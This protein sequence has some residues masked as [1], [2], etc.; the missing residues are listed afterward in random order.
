MEQVGI[1]AAFV[2]GVLSFASPCVLPLVPAYLSFISGVSLEEM[3]KEKEKRRVLLKVSLNSLGF[4]IGFSFI[5]VLLGA[6][7]SLMG[8]FVASNKALL[9]KIAGVIVVIFGLH[10]TGIFRLKFLDYEKRI[11]LRRGTFGVFTSFILGL[12]FATG[13]TP[14]IGPILGSILALAAV[15]ETV[16]KGMILLGF[17]SLGMATPFF[18]SAIFTN[19][20]LTLLGRVRKHMRKVEL[21]AGLF[22]I[23]VGILIFSGQLQFISSLLPSYDLKY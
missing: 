22:L 10:L 8:Q 1:L 2:A 7:F 12:A 15:Q 23:F 6:S 14:C 21:A 13:W 20:F 18:L 16:G 17:Y 4:I 11:N 19:I 3:R 9:E 5:F